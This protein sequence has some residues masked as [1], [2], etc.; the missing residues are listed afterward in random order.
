MTR[1][2]TYVLTAAAAAPYAA[3]C[4]IF[5]DGLFTGTLWSRH[6]WSASFLWT[7][8]F[9]GAIVPAGI[10]QARRLPAGGVDLTPTPAAATPGQVD[11]PVAWK[12]LLLRL[13]GTPWKRGELFGRVKTPVATPPRGMT[14]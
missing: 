1:H 13:A 9:L 12:L 11:D 6:E 10:V 8:L 14:A 2:R 3:L 5:A 7:Y 4:W